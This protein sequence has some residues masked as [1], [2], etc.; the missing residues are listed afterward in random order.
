MSAWKIAKQ[1]DYHVYY[2]DDFRG[3]F[4]TEAEAK[5][6]VRGF[7]AGITYGR[8]VQIKRY[9]SGEWAPQAAETSPEQPSYKHPEKDILNLSEDEGVP[10]SLP[11]EPMADLTGDMPL[12]D[13]P[14]N[15]IA[16]VQS[17]E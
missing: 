14:F 15:G 17:Q 4:E 1:I 8:A 3:D 13:G 16:S 9:E 10:A 7:E 2:G 5:A 11:T 6:F 12:N